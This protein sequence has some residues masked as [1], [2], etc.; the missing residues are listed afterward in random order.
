MFNRI[1]QLM[2]MYDETKNP[3]LVDNIREIVD[4]EINSGDLYACMSLL[5]RVINNEI[6][7]QKLI[8]IG[9]YYDYSP[10][11]SLYHPYFKCYCLITSEK[12]NLLSMDLLKLESMIGKNQVQILRLLQDKVKQVLVLESED[13]NN[14][15]DVIESNVENKYWWKKNLWWILL[16][17]GIIL[18]VLIVVLSVHN[19]MNTDYAA[20]YLRSHGQDTSIL[21]R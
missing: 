2:K 12:D 18:F 5:D 13:P 20:E 1:N 15:I 14:N 4:K 21:H 9:A 19:I 8:E 10:Y 16:G 17:V 6:S 11:N 7:L 3:I